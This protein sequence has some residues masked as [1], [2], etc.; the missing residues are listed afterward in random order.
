MNLQTARYAVAAGIAVVLVSIVALVVLLILQGGVRSDAPSIVGLLTFFGTLVTLLTNLLATGGVAHTT[1][2][3]QQQT[4]GLSA[5][6]EVVEKAAGIAPPA[7]EV[8]PGH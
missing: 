4:N 1:G 3:I 2:Q 5:R 6:V 7:G 8:P